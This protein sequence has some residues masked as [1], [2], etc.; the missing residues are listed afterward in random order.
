MISKLACAGGVVALVGIS[1]CKHTPPDQ[2]VPQV[3]RSLAMSA[4]GAS[5]WV[6]NPESDSISQIDVASRS[7]K[8]EIP[9]GSTPPAIDPTTCRYDPAIR[10]R[11]I[12]LIDSMGKAY[13]AGQLAN[14]V[15]VVDTNTGTVTASI[16]VGAEPTAVV[17]SP[18]GSTVY[19]VSHEADTV[20]KIDT[21]TDAVTATVNVNDHPWGASLRADG[22]LLY[23]SYLLLNPSVTVIDTGSFA[24]ATTTAVPPFC[25]NSTAN[26]DRCNS[27][28][29]DPLIPSGQVRGEY[30]VVP[31][32]NSGE[33]WVPHML[34]A[35]N[36]VQPTLA[37]NT[38]VFPTVTRLTPGAAS[39]DNRILFKPSSTKDFNLAPDLQKT[40]FSTWFSFIDV[41]SGPHDVA[42]TSDGTLAFVAYGNSENVM[43]FDAET[44]DEVGYQA[45]ITTDLDNLPVGLLEGIVLDSSETHAFIQGRSTH[46]VAVLDIAQQSGSVIFTPETPIECLSGADPMSVAPGSSPTCS[47]FQSTSVALRRGMRLFYSANAAAFPVTQNAWVACANCHLEGQ[48]DA[49]T[50]QFLQGPRD[51]PSNVGGPINTGFLFRQAVRNNVNQYDETIQ[52]EQGGNYHL[53]NASQV[54]DLN[55]L[56][57]FVNF[58]IPFPQNPNITAN[59]TLT[60]SQQNGQQLFQMYCA[61]C[62]TGPYFTDSGAGNATL[63]LCS[64][65]VVLHDIGTCVTTGSN[66]DHTSMTTPDLGT[67]C[68]RAACQFDTPTLRS[69]FASAP[70]FHD[71]SA[72][73]LDDAVA[74]VPFSATLSASD[75]ADLVAYLK[76]L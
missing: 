42:F 60:Q 52:N 18:D 58:A 53:S 44:G 14:K 66:P 36:T 76:T 51:T 25:P 75:Q 15:F 50:W 2:G 63:D 48:T 72:L 19:V 20:A 68:Q 64:G 30:T 41:A 12:A 45:P 35:T 10:P 73:T 26:G 4:D 23:V 59:G 70:Y 11:A 37:F 29:P 67:A 39:V 38:T 43:A 24:V 61:S 21:K 5:L 62:H 16:P 17:A 34:L 9:L 40:G 46:N 47:K 71:G 13:V 6:V 69:I 74:R 7:L 1:A 57:D 56:A 32:P 22:S 33:L 54:P 27:G 8:R 49:V 3:S 65:P 55:A 28:P 31:R